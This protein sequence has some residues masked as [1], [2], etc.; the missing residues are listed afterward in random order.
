MS[1]VHL[2]THSHY[3]LLDG[4]SKVDDLVNRCVEYNMPAMAL[5]DHGVMYGL[6]EFY[7]KASKAGIR[8]ILG[9]EAYVARFGH[10]EKR[11]DNT[12]PYHLLLLAADEAGYQPSRT[13][14]VFIISREL[15]WR[16]WLATVTG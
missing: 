12:R 11:P 9:V 10:T 5:T 8:P 7:Q 4:L 14:M 2:H 1:V 16:C 3:S 15:T 6:I 13:W